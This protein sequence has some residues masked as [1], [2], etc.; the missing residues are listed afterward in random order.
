MRDNGKG[1]P[2]LVVRDPS[3]VTSDGKQNVMILEL[4]ETDTAGFYSPKTAAPMDN[5][6]LRKYKVLLEREVR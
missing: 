4:K 6:Y 5:R 2:I 3:V 1:D